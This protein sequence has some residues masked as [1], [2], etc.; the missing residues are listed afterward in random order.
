M[1]EDL[2]ETGFVISRVLEPKPLDVLQNI[3]RELFMRLSR[4]PSRLMIKAYQ[5]RI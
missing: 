3:D 4:E 2:A 1:S 5:P